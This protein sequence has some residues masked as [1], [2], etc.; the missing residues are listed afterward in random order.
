MFQDTVKTSNM[1]PPL[2]APFQRSGHMPVQGNAYFRRSGVVG[3]QEPVA[4]H[5]EAV[6]RHWEPMLRQQELINMPFGPSVNN[7]AST[8]QAQPH[9]TRGACDNVLFEV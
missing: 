4:M 2:D 8:S 3:E 5:Q 9:G 7:L 1:V 6:A